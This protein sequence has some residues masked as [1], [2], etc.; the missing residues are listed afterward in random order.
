[1]LLRGVHNTYLLLIINLL[2]NLD[3]EVENLQ[4]TGKQ[5]QALSASH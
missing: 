4:E 2:V 3:L 5:M 1:M